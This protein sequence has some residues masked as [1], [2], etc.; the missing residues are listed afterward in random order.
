VA[1]AED[2]GD[3]R[4]A[5]GAGAADPPRPSHVPIPIP[6]IAAPTNTAGARIDRI[7]TSLIP[8]TRD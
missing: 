2:P 4:A 6:K 3:A 7:G 8:P 5:D 1:M